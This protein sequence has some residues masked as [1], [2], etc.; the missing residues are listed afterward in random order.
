MAE[1]TMP[2]DG[3]P[4]DFYAAHYARFDS[5][6]SAALRHEVYGEDLGQTGWR[7]AAEQTEIEQWLRLGPNVRVLDV[8]CGSGGPSL[9]MVERTGCHVTGIDL[10]AVGVG[11]AK[12]AATARGLAGQTEFLAADCGGP[13]PFADGTFDALVCIDAINHLPGRSDTL[14]EWARLLKRGGRLLYTDPC[15]ITG[16]VAKP[17][18]DA[19]ADLGFYLFVPSGHDEQA[20][21]AVGLRLLQREDRTAACADI[22]QRWH[23]FR[24]RYAEALKREEGAEA[25]ARRQR[26]LTITAELAGSRRLGR[27]LYVAEHAGQDLRAGS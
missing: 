9:A 25:Y 11:R 18:L 24:A 1:Q 19:R 16:P 2:F 14:R 12:A 23:D 10:E 20:L 6:L 5:A 4:F 26:F 3:G 7:T 13:L 8:C 21:P 17:E 27:V 15:V 22:A